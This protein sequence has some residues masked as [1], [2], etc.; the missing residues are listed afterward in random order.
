MT[1]FWCSRVLWAYLQVMG[2]D[3]EL[4]VSHQIAIYSV[5]DIAGCPG[6][7]NDLSPVILLA[8]LVIFS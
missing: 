8:F 5:W 3:G 6:Y 4:V 1:L 2:E 7:S